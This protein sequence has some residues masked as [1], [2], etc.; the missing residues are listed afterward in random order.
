L[1]KQEIIVELA[2]YVCHLSAQKEE[3]SSLPRFFKKNEVKNRTECSSAP[4]AKGQAP[5]CCLNNHA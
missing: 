5:P 2:D 4:E 1:Q 3:E